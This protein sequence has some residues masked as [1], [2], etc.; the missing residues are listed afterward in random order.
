MDGKADMGGFAVVH[1]ICK[2]KL[3]GHFM[4]VVLLPQHMSERPCP[5]TKSC[6]KYHALILQAEIKHEITA[7]QQSYI[8]Q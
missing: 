5:T 7:A 1:V 4:L 3:K 2:I 8:S 6:L